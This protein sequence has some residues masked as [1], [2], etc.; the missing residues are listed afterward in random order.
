M[1]VVIDNK[2]NRFKELISSSEFILI[3]A[4]AGLTE[5]AGINYAGSIFSDNFKDF[6]EKYGVKDLYTSSFYPFKTQEEFWAYWAKH[7]H[8]IRFGIPAAQLYI[9]LLKIILSKKHF[10]ITTNVD[11]QF[12]KAGFN[13]ESIFPVQGDYAFLQCEKGCHNKLYYNEDIVLE[14]ISKTTDCIIPS[15]LVPVCP[16]CSGKMDVNI[17]KNS[18]FVQ[19]EEWHLAY[20]RYTDFLHESFGKKVVLIELGV[21]FN[22]PGIIRIPFEKITQQ[23]PQAS[24][25]RINT[26]YPFCEDVN[27]SKTILFDSDIKEVIMSL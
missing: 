22:T 6:I 24:L 11:H 17:R 25:V 9:D 19:N 7:I 1:N 18:H 16:V 23:Y 8:V 12:Y 15:S 13:S 3:G 14:M 4:G 27:V 21:G 20:Q 5:S 26:E 10:V 2:I